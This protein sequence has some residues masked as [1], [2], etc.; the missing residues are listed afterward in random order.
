MA[1]LN[2]WCRTWGSP[3]GPPSPS[4]TRTSGA[5]RWGRWGPPCWGPAPAPASPRLVWVFWTLEL[6]L[7]LELSLLLV[8]ELEL[9]LLF[10]L[11]LVLELSL[12]LELTLKLS[13]LVLELELSHLLFELE[14]ELSLWLGLELSRVLEVGEESCPWVRMEQVLGT[15]TSSGWPHRCQAWEQKICVMF[16]TIDRYRMK[17]KSRW[18]LCKKLIFFFI[19]VFWNMIT[20]FKLERY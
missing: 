13:P 17:K 20:L 8:L 9:S 7:E 4:A 16:F 2:T 1:S 12:L 6:E 10:Q 14:L 3:W 5:G 15:G 19:Y 18:S 11:E